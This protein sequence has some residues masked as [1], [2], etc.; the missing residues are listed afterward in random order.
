MP[1]LIETLSGVATFQ[2]KEIERALLATGE[3]ILLEPYKRYEVHPHVWV[4]KT[5]AERRAAV[6]KFLA[7]R[8]PNNKDMV[9]STDGHLIIATTPSAGKKPHQAQRRR[10]T[11]TKPKKIIN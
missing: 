11:R 3:Y 7:A 6:E 9:C 10:A 4:G 8:K 2:L 5:Q 1:Q